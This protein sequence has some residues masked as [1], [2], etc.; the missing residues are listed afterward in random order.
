VKIFLGILSSSILSRW[1]S[2]IILCPFIQFTTFSP[3]LISSSSQFVLLFHSP[4]S[5]LRPY[6]VLN[7]FLSKISTACSS[8][9]V[10]AYHSA[11]YD[12]TGLI[13]VLYNKILVAL[14]LQYTATKTV[15]NE[16][17]AD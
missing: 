5:Y 4:F 11:P 16:C 2:Q 3:L 17:P 10:I 8:F 7:I 14:L 1:P 9:F 12:T 13:N 15:N 6:I